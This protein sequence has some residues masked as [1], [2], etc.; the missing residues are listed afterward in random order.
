[1]AEPTLSALSAGSLCL[2]RAK[3]KVD[4]VNTKRTQNFLSPLHFV[5]M[6]KQNIINIK[7]NT[8]II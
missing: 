1:M 3:E 4:T 7:L 2:S 6:Q 8:E 5:G